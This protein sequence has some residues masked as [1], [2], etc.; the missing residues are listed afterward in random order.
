MHEAYADPSQLNNVEQQSF[1]IEG[2]LF[3][4][5]YLPRFQIRKPF[6]MHAVLSHA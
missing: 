6:E 5:H 3:S 2:C 4:V 1:V